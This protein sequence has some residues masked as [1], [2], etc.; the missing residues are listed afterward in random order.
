FWA[1][2]PE[3]EVEYRTRAVAFDPINRHLW[4]DD[5][6]RLLRVRNLDDWKGKLLVDAV[7]GQGDKTSKQ[8]NRGNQKPAADS[9]AGANSIRFARLGNLFVVDNTYEGHPNGRVVAFLA[10]DLRG[11][12]GMF[13]NV[14]AKKVYCVERFDQTEYCRIHLPVDHPFSP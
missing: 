10:E 7:I 13:P 6:A 1:D 2:E 11:L 8:V 9:L 12:K 5:G 14:Q 3:K 4:L